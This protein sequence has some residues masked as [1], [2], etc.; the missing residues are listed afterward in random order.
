MPKPFA[1]YAWHPCR[2]RVS[3]L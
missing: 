1:A 2:T 3:E